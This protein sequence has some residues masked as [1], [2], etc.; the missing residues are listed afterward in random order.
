MFWKTEI[1][2][3]VCHENALLDR[4]K[5]KLTTFEVITN[6][7]TPKLYFDIDYKVSINEYD[8]TLEEIIE[9]KGEEYLRNSL[10]TIFDVEPS[11]AIATSHSK[12]YNSK[13]GKYS[14]RYYVSNMLGNKKDIE[15]FVKQINLYI[16]SKDKSDIDNIYDYINEET[17]P[18]LFDEG[19]YDSNRKMRCLFTSKPNENRPLILKKGNI[20]DTIITGFFDN[21]SSILKMVKQTKP[22]D[23]IYTNINMEQIDDEEL[24]KFCDLINIKYLDYYADWIKIL[25]ALKRIDN[26]KAIAVHISKKSPKYN[27][28]EFNQIWDGLSDK[29]NYNI[30]TI[31]YYSKLS[32]EIE[33]KKLM[34]KKKH[35]FLNQLL[36]SYGDEDIA[37]TFYELYGT[38]FIYN[39]GVYYCW[40]NI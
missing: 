29:Y 8:E 18:K 4:I 6:N 5:N 9:N 38:D 39:N 13:Y 15:E 28:A 22:K 23:I 16:A 12:N 30:G 27:E 40:N 10:K 3:L 35:A 7:I 1:P 31:Y 25:M 19:I 36:L 26:S 34:N 37:K 17:C 20:E 21:N 14:V 32:N 33:Y 24:F 2:F 11:I